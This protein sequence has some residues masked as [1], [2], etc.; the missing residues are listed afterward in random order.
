MN[1]KY[2][3]GSV[4]VIININHLTCVVKGRCCKAKRY[5][6]CVLTQCIQATFDNR[7]EYVKGIYWLGLYPF[8]KDTTAKINNFVSTI[9]YDVIL[10]YAKMGANY[11]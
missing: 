8:Y 1:R 11:D 5:I 10:P 6:R 4:E 7:L 2:F 3:Y 9:I